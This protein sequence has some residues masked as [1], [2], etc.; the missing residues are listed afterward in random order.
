MESFRSRLEEAGR[1]F[2]GW[3]VG[4][5]DFVESQEKRKMGREVPWGL[6]EHRF[7]RCFC[8]F[9]GN[10]GGIS[11][12]GPPKPTFFVVFMVNNLVLG[13]QNF[14]FL[15]FWGLME[16]YIVFFPPRL[17]EKGYLFGE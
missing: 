14:Y 15:W 3:A 13:G 10:K 16:C 12:H 2:F 1:L 11:N 17:W 5:G 9:S 6:R 4:W 8:W 7:S